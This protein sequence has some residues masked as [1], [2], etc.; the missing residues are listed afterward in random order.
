MINDDQKSL[1][2]SLSHSPSSSL[3]LDQ[4]IWRLSVK[5]PIR[6]S[7]YT[8][9]DKA[10]PDSNVCK[11]LRSDERR[12]SVPT[13]HKSGSRRTTKPQ[14]ACSNRKGPSVS[15]SSC[16][17]LDMSVCSFLT[18]KIE[19]TVS[20]FR[21]MGLLGHKHTVNQVHSRHSVL[22]WSENISF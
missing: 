14:K 17:L 6:Y 8:V 16:F 21:L 20:G 19:M 11:V 5:G 2:F 4:I 10:T 12:R 18:F 1:C 7:A 22:C 9:H 13:G 15:S 3:S